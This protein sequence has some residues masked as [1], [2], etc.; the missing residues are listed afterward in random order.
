MVASDIKDI[1]IEVQNLS[2]L[3][4]YNIRWLYDLTRD[5]WELENTEHSRKIASSM[6]WIII[7]IKK[8][9]I[10]HLHLMFHYI[11]ELNWKRHLSATPTC[12]LFQFNLHSNNFPK[13]SD[14]SPCT[15]SII[16]N[17]ILFYIIFLSFNTK[18]KD[19]IEKWINRTHGY[20]FECGCSTRYRT[21]EAASNVTFFLRTVQNKNQM[22]SQVFLIIYNWW[23]SE[24]SESSGRKLLIISLFLVD[25]IKT[26]RLNQLFRN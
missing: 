19:F 22:K 12:A 26:N 25:S 11:F 23:T 14:N 1:G 4:N 9:I 24:F 6:S 20:L 15:G 10:L 5:R 7:K 3:Y 17:W 21:F 13:I 16:G 8:I 18:K 2:E